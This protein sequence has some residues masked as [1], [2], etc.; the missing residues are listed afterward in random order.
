MSTMQRA[1]QIRD[2]MI[3]LAVSMGVDVP[4][5][6]RHT[7]MQIFIDM[8]EKRPFTDTPDPFKQELDG[9]FRFL[10]VPSIPVVL[11]DDPFTGLGMLIIT[12]FQT[13]QEAVAWGEKFQEKE[14]DNPCWNAL[15][16]TG[17]TISISYANP[18]TTTQ[19]DRY[20]RRIYRNSRTGFASLNV[21]GPFRSDEYMAGYMERDATAR[22]S[23]EWQHISMDKMCE[24]GGHTYS[25]I[26][27][28]EHKDIDE[29]WAS[30]KRMTDPNVSGP[31]FDRKELEKL[32]RVTLKI[33]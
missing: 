32:Y 23:T 14:Y 29:L 7:V 28:Y 15:N 9:V 26:A 10:K 30:G 17:R 25:G 2:N 5:S 27:S 24:H 11:L 3:A 16:L 6:Q 1:I 31:Q 21:I 20:A 18:G 12:G 8:A 22:R 33:G 13:Y 19:G 4:E